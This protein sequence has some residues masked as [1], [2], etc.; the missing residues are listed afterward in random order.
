MGK[1]YRIGRGIE[2]LGDQRSLHSNALSARRRHPGLWHCVG[3]GRTGAA[4]IG[5]AG[6]GGDSKFAD[7]KF[8]DYSYVCLMK[9]AML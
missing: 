7:N 9:Q 5:R 4:K 3:D 6:A 8:A 1:G 2:Y